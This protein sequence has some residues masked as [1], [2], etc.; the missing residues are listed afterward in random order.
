MRK[1]AVQECTTQMLVA[2]WGFDTS[3][4]TKKEL[5]EQLIAHGCTKKSRGRS[6]DFKTSDKRC[7]NWG[8][9]VP[10]YV[11]SLTSPTHH[12]QT[13]SDGSSSQQTTNTVTPRFCI[14]LSPR[15]ICQVTSCR[16][17]SC[18]A[19]VRPQI[20]SHTK[21]DETSDPTTNIVVRIDKHRGKHGIM[22]TV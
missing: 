21:F 9:L 6:G 14:S 12:P 11:F 22:H 18:F 7:V 3:S 1:K 13:T 4:M 5:T 10:N 16:W 8:G 15:C 19:D 20:Y 17:Y 2:A